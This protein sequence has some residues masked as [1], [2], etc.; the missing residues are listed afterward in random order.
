MYAISCFTKVKENIDL[1]PAFSAADYFV[2]FLNLAEKFINLTFARYNTEKMLS[3]I[4]PNLEG[5]Q[6]VIGSS[7]TSL[8]INIPAPMGTNV[9]IDTFV[10]SDSYGSSGLSFY[11]ITKSKGAK[12]GITFKIFPAKISAKAGLEF[13]ALD[14]FYYLEAYMDFLNSSA[15]SFNKFQASGLKESAKNRKDMQ[16]KEKEASANSGAFERYLKLLKAIRLIFW[17]RLG[18]FVCRRLNPT[19]IFRKY[20]VK[21]C[22]S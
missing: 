21:Q 8:S 12:A 17:M 18:L 6:S 7:S 3:Q 4:K 1:D 9:N 5:I 16:E 22:N 11:T 15:S 20:H 2:N 13:A 14:L 10:S 19:I